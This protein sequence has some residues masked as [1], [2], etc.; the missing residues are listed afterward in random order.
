MIIELE[1][2]NEPLTEEEMDALISAIQILDFNEE[3]ERAQILK[4]LIS[5]LYNNAM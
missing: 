2:Q 4:D 5:K 1:N 3:W